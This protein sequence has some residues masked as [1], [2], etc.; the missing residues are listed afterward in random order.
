[1]NVNVVG[2]A[3]C[4]PPQPGIPESAN[5]NTKNTPSLQI[6][7]MRHFILGP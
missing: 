2:P 5:A 7:R 6:N 4:E 1:M 3:E